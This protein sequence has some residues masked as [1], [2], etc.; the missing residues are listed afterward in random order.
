MVGATLFCI[1]GYLVREGKVPAWENNECP[2]MQTEGCAGHFDESTTD[3][4]S[5]HPC[6]HWMC[7]PCAQAHIHIQR[8]GRGPICREVVKFTQRLVP[9][10][11]NMS[12]GPKPS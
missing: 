5:L 3:W 2:T 1:V 6:M 8:M 10:E 9:G 11:L 12:Q 7:H 4:C